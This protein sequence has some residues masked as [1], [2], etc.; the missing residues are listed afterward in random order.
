MAHV[1][2]ILNRD[3]S[4]LSKRQ[5]DVAVEDYL[6]KGYLKEALINFIAFLGW[7]PGEGDEQGI[8]LENELI[9]KITL[10]KVQSSGAVFN[11][12]KLDWMNNEY[13]KN[14]DIN[15]L[16]LLSF[17]YFEKSEFDTSDKER[18]VKVLSAVRVISTNLMK[19]LFI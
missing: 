8:F 7:N 12:D 1:P 2:L 5:G 10:E 18:M 3:K 15:E 17:P 16:A 14:Y 19:Y 4:K 13:I 6:N 11:T 9:K